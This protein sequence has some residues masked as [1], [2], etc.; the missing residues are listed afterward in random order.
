MPQKKKLKSVLS[1]KPEPVPVQPLRELVWRAAE[2]EYI[3]KGPLWFLGIGFVGLVLAAIALWQRNFFF[4]VFVVIAASVLVS[5]GRKRPQVVEFRI[6]DEGVT[7]GKQ[8]ASFERLQDFSFRERPGR[9]DELTLTRKSVV[10]PFVRIPIDA[11]SVEGARKL[12][13]AKL[14][15]VPREAS[16]IDL[17]AERLGF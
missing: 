12:L 9:L 15:E 16:L 3:E 11:H 13:A 17:I 10:A 14:P 6:T 8:F 7:V 1:E 5:L 4:A 2:Y